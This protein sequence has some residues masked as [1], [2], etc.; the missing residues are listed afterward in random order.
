[1]EAK[2]SPLH[3]QYIDLERGCL[4]NL[5]QLKYNELVYHLVETR[6]YQLCYQQTRVLKI[7]EAYPGR[8][9]KNKNYRTP[10][11]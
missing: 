2:V 6:H 10:F 4:G 5:K 8:Y 11:T 7:I 3:V 9:N 1:M